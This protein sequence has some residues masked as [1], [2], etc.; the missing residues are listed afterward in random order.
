MQSTSSFAAFT[1]LKNLFFNSSLDIAGRK[2]VLFVTEMEK[3]CGACSASRRSNFNI[4]SIDAE[5]ARSIVRCKALENAN[6]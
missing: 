2:L 5:I 4:V 3:N 6:S 1:Q